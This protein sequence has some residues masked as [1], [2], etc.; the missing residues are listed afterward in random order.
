[1]AIFHLTTKVF[2]RGK[3][4]SA[5]AAAAYRSGETLRDEQTGEQKSYQTRSARIAFEGVFAPAD[6]PE[7][8]RQRN[9]LWNQAE[10]TETRKDAR[11]AREIEVALPH[12]LTDQQREYL[13][14]DFVREAFVRK[15]YVVDVAIHAPDRQSDERN[16][17]AHILIAE[18][19]IGA[20]GFAATK[21]PIMNKRETLEGWREQFAHLTNRHLERHG[22]DARVDHRTLEAQGIDREPTVHVGYAGM[23]IDARGGQ[24]DRMQALRDIMERNDIRLELMRLEGQSGPVAAP[25]ENPAAGPARLDWRETKAQEAWRVSVDERNPEAVKPGEKALE[26]V[27]SATGTVSKL[28]D[29]MLDL[30]SGPSAKPA[31]QKI[32]MAD[33]VSDPAARKAFQLGQLAAAREASEADKA[34]DRIRAD[35]EAG[36]RLKAE[37]ISSLTH[38]HQTSIHRGGDDM[39]RQMVEDARKRAEQYWR[40]DGRER[41]R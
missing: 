25:V 33:Y 36:R 12:E 35:W 2:S 29:F 24:S 32:D 21:D 5:I 14:K 6:A 17:H 10:R 8:A 38:E 37:D 34:L 7:W 4:Q 3:G 27:D 1:M 39:V 31:P 30:L 28:G 40:S 15:G 26:V 16:H 23:E 19:R 22:H 41:E 13:V 11:L 9:E 18:R 20:D